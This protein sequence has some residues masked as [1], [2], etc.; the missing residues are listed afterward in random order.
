MVRWLVRLVIASVLTTAA[1][2]FGA[3]WIHNLAH[4]PQ[5]GYAKPQWW[6]LLVAVLL[7]FVVLAILFPFRDEE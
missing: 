2:L 4:F 5:P 6:Q 3:A 1:T 7:F